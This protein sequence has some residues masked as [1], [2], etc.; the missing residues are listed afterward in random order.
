MSERLQYLFINLLILAFVAY[1]SVFVVY[2]GEKA[3]LLHFGEIVRSGNQVRL[4]SPGLHLKWPFIEKPY[5]MDARLQIGMVDV[6]K[7]QS[8]EQV[9]LMVDF[10]FK[11][12]IK[13][14]EKF[15]KVSGGGALL[16]ECC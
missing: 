3:F 10:Y 15:F 14:F 12:R 8:V 4:Y 11:W 5:L 7:I 2:E 6:D 16:L 1:Q 9:Y 13:D